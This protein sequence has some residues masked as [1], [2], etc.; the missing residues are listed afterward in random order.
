MR[1]LATE[2]NESSNAVRVELNRLTEAGML[3]SVKE[4]NKLLYRV[5]ELHPLYEPINTMI[6]QYV[7]VDEIISNVIKGLGKIEKLYLTGSLAKGL[8]TD[9]IDI[10]LV[11]DLN[12]EYLLSKIAKIEQGIGKKI[13]Y[14]VYSTAEAQKKNFNSSEY[15]MIY[16]P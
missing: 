7:G 3:S 5:N 6:K 2:L 11:G 13:R 14:I 10:V 8:S 4:G 12:Q 9:I 15:L 16:A 1:A